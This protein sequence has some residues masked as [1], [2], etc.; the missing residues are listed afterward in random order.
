M[1]KPELRP[2]PEQTF[3]ADPALD[4]VMAYAFALS[5][6]VWVLR[7]RLHRLEAALAAGGTLDPKAFEARV[8]TAEEQAA[9]AADRAE[10]VRALMDA[11]AGRQASNNL[12]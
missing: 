4:R 1:S 8:P 2:R 10:F 11:V 3:F 12:E 7:D 5:A 9:I 6:E